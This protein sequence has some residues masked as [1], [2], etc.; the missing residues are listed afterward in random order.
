MPCIVCR[1]TQEGPSIRKGQWSYLRC[2]SCGLLSSSPIP[3][4]RQIEDH[5]REKFHVGNYETLR[6]Y[7]SQYRHV[8]EQMANWVAPKQ[9]ERMLDVGC[10]TGDLIDVLRGR[11]A[12]AYGLELQPEAVQIAQE[13][14]PGRVF[15]ADVHGSMFPA[16]PYD[17]ITMMGLI[18]HV[19][20]PVNFIRRARSLL[21]PNGRL[22]LQTPDASSLLARAMRSHWPPLA[23]IEHIH[24]FTRASMRKL[25]HDFGFSNLKFRAHVKTLPVGYIYENLNNFGPEWRWAFRPVHALLGDLALPF[26]GGEMLVSAMT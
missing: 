20:D 1:E 23:P 11:G 25:L 9:G 15:Q 5:Y 26:Y 6:R 17:T 10:F 16:G 12:D 22:L 4:S 7:A 8:Y 24:L 14:M 2:T 19:V 13:R 21:T 18:E 3:S